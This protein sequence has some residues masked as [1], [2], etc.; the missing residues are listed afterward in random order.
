MRKIILACLFI[1]TSCFYSCQLN[2]LRSSNK[3]ET[4][5]FSIEKIKDKIFKKDYSEIKK[6]AIINKEYKLKDSLVSS[7]GVSWKAISLY[8]N[9]TLAILAETNWIDTNT[10]S[11]V[12]ILDSNIVGRSSVSVGKTINDIKLLIDTNALN[13]S[14]DGYLDFTDKEDK[15]IRYVMDISNYPDLFFGVGNFNEI[16]T[17]LKV[18]Q[19]VIIKLNP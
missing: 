12:T 5:S 8:K 2:D 7:E 6:D 3:K 1:T 19:I 9:N 4:H 17:E 18:K 13:N 16:P 15:E 10:I 11:R 14:P